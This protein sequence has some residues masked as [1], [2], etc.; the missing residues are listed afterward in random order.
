MF[1]YIY[2][3]SPVCN[4]YTDFI[5][6]PQV[7]VQQVNSFVSQWAWSGRSRSCQIRAIFTIR[8]CIPRQAIQE[9]SNVRNLD[10]YL[11]INE[12]E[13]PKP[14]IYLPGQCE[15]FPCGIR[16]SCNYETILNWMT[17]DFWDT[18]SNIP[19][20]CSMIWDLVSP[21]FCRFEDQLTSDTN[22]MV[23]VSFFQ[24]F[25]LCQFRCFENEQANKQTNKQIILL[26]QCVEW[27]GKKVALVA[28][29]Q[30]FLAV[31][32][33]HTT[34]GVYCLTGVYMLPTTC[35]TRTEKSWKILWWLTEA[36]FQ[37]H[38][39]EVW[40]CLPNPMNCIDFHD[41]TGFL[42]S[43]FR[44]RFFQRS[45]C[46]KGEYCECPDKMC[47]QGDAGGARKQLGLC[48]IS[49]TWGRE[50]EM[51]CRGFSLSH[52]F[53]GMK[54]VEWYQKTFSKKMF[55]PFDWQIELVLQEE[56]RIKEIWWDPLPL[57]FKQIPPK[58]MG[59]W[60]PAG[61]AW[62]LLMGHKSWHSHLTYEGAAKKTENSNW[63]NENEEKSCDAC[64]YIHI[65]IYDMRLKVYIYIYVYFRWAIVVYIFICHYIIY[66]TCIM[67]RYH[68]K[69]LMQ[70]I[71]VQY[72]ETVRHMCVL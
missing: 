33:T 59:P 52:F 23:M 71:I 13:N 61:P 30:Y 2:I 17:H 57:G 25:S 55:F 10:R 60:I 41:S 56:K 67:I 68:L 66:I 49:C 35:L 8:D 11:P 9:D 32:T 21:C 7:L 42:C 26:Q 64:I 54:P 6:F 31:C 18:R 24:H 22:N 3:V 34:T 48:W 29:N 14:L 51:D 38:F 58:N 45:A 1:F 43:T 44:C 36:G 28:Y 15:Q 40:S 5:K 4:I 47:F 39:K 50:G 20:F 12:T 53:T 70:Y 27:F 19:Y 63:W 69:I 62:G 72:L 46:R 37:L 65:Y 16:A